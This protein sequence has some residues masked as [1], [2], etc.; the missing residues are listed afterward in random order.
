ML[1]AAG[2]IL[3]VAGTLFKIQHWPLA[4]LFMILSLIILF[5]VV[6]PWYTWQTWKD[7]SHISSAFIFLIIGSLLIIVPGALI[8]LSL[9][10]MYN[11][12]YYPHLEQEQNVYNVRLTLNKSILE[13]YHDSLCY[14]KMELLNNKT[15]DALSYLGNIEK[16]MVEES[17]GKPGNAAP[18]TE[19]VR[20]TE[21]GPEIR[22]TRL[23]S[24]FNPLPARDLL[25][26][27]STVRQKINAV[28]AE[29]MNY[30]TDLTPDKDPKKF[31]ELL[32]PSVY[33]P[34]G[35]PGQADLTLLSALHSVEIL[36]N[37][38]LAVESCMLK[39][40]AKQ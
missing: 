4:S 38:L 10:N 2:S 9:Q 16:Q 35:I 23:V 28:M 5:L 27:G 6:L 7:A 24:P 15:L 40:I 21:N 20:Q 31:K 39:Y 32:D 14:Q 34:G 37:N 8:N 1:G 36:K 30:V 13:K 29:Y 22:F 11:A 3:Y 19:S 17:E 26:P 12:G 33:L 25:M 18:G